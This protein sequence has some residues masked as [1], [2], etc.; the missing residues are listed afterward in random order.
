MKKTIIFLTTTVL[1]WGMTVTALADNFDPIEKDIYLEDYKK[2][3]PLRPGTEYTFSFVDGNGYD[4]RKGKREIDD[5]YHVTYDDFQVSDIEFLTSSGKKAPLS[6]KFYVK[7]QSND[8]E[9]TIITSHLTSKQFEDYYGTGGVKVAFDIEVERSWTEYGKYN[10][11]EDKG[12]KIISDRIYV[13]INTPNTITPPTTNTDSQ[14]KY[15]M[16]I[17]KMDADPFLSAG[18]EY[19]LPLKKYNDDLLSEDDLK[20]FDFDLEILNGADSLEIAEIVLDKNDNYLLNIKPSSKNLSKDPK[21]VEIITRIRN[22]GD[23]GY[24]TR[25]YVI[26]MGY[27]PVD[28][29]SFN[30]KLNTLEPYIKLDKKIASATASISN[31]GSIV[32]R[33]E[34]NGLFNFAYNTDVP[35]ELI[36]SNFPLKSMKFHN[37]SAKPTFTH[38]VTVRVKADDKVYI[39]KHQN[40]VYTEIPTTYQDGYRSF[41]TTQLGD[42]VVSTKSLKGYKV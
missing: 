3:E 37:F 16:K 22:K 2:D 14:S 12:R 18:R 17:D 11:V 33:N 20:K 40:G 4:I 34:G 21:K 30:F 25:K 31:F 42:Y 5:D 38:P 26:Q 32:F 36:N 35:Q 27:R 7:H 6:H 1:M 29:N 10:K 41:N 9:V 13:E 8:D 24:H 19:N 28:I 39:Y 23:S 15:G